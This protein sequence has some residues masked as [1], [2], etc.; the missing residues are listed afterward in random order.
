MNITTKPHYGIRALLEIAK[1]PEGEGV[2]QKDIALNQ[3]LPNKYLDH[4]IRELKVANLISNRGRKK[5]GYILS[6]PAS[7]ITVYAIYRAFEPEL[8]LVS[9]VDCKCECTRAVLQCPTQPLWQ[10]LNKRMIQFMQV[11]SLQDL[12]DGKDF[13][14]IRLHE[15][16]ETEKVEEKELVEA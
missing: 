7:E 3:E 4:I 12:M 10:E 2:L 6:K 13:S 16:G 11:V 9:C 1:A 15:N 5:S 14:L 8:C